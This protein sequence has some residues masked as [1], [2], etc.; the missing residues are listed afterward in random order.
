[1]RPARVDRR[2]RLIRIARHAR[3]MTLILQDAGDELAD[4][5]FVVDDE[6]VSNHQDDPILS[7]SAGAPSCSLACRGSLIRTFAP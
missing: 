4:V 1:M 2:H 6:N 7:F 3:A 5:L